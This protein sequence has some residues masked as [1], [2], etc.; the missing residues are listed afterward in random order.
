MKTDEQIKA[1]YYKYQVPSFK[2]ITPKQKK[3]QLAIARFG[4][5]FAYWNKMTSFQ[6]SGM[7]YNKK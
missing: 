5:D 3:I 1:E 4:K 2:Y 7:L 6:L